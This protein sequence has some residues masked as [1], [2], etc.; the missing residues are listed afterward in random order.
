MTVFGEEAGSA[1]LR[2][3]IGYVTQARQRLRR[4]HRRREPRVLRAGARCRPA[5]VDAASRPSTSPTTGDQVVGRLSGGQR[6][7][8]SLAVALLGE[9]GPAGARRAD[10][11]PRP[12]A[13]PRPVGAVP[14]ARRSGAVR[15]RVQPRDGRGRALRP[16]AADAGG[17]DHR[18]R[19]PR[20]DPAEDRRRRHRA[21]FLA[22][23]EEEAT[24]ERHPHHPRSGEPRSPRRSPSPSGCSPSS[25]ATTARSHAAG[26][27]VPA[28]HPALVDV[29]GPARAIFDLVGPA[30]LAM[31]PFIVMFLV[32]SVTTLRERSSGTLERLLAMPMGKLDFLLGYA[33]AF[34]LVAAV[35]SALAVGVSVGLL[36]LDVVGPVWLLTLVAVADAV[37]GTALGLLVSRVRADRVPGRPVHA[38]AG[39]PADPAVRAVRPARGSCPPRSRRSATCC[40]C[41]TPSTRCSGSPAPPRRARCGRTSRWWPASRWPV[42][43]SARPPCGGVPRTCVWPRRRALRSSAETTRTDVEPRGQDMSLLRQPLLLLARSEKVKKARQHDARLRGHREQLRPR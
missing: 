7:R 6:S 13:A 19:H 11:R 21:A 34:G 31:F 9:P 26:A 25:A 37:L 20:R 16:A 2:D 23:V 3:R 1:P 14:P 43:P 5:E 33:L 39:D 8:A 15:V 10:G 4:P 24:D 38:G 18:R 29:R 35:Q 27:A 42:W 22:L 28:D 30:L 36:G 32:T 40:R 12:G 41:R 17:P